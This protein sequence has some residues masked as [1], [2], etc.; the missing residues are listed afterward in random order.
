[1]VNIY[2]SNKAQSA[3]AE[4]CFIMKRLTLENTHLSLFL[5]QSFVA[6]EHC[7]KQFNY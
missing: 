2:C 4:G 6:V 1:M 7:G 5:S 3:E